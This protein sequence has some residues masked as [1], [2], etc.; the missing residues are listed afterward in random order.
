MQQHDLALELLRLAR[1]D[2]NAARLL[3]AHAEASDT[4][5]GFHCQQAAE[6]ALKAVLAEA[7]V[8]FPRTHNLLHLMQ[9]LGDHGYALPPELDDL[10]LL[11]PY[12]V[13]MRYGGTIEL[14]LER[15]PGLD[16]ASEAIRWADKRIEGR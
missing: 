3:S 16:L 6:K 11:T 2:L 4:I 13:A 9:L 15:Q 5:I 10:R 1:D 7:D 8:D 12:A 14:G